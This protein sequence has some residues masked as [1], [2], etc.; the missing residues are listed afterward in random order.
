MSKTQQLPNVLQSKQRLYSQLARRLGDLKQ[1][2][3]KTTDLIEIFQ[4]DLEAM[5]TFT[6]IQA[7]L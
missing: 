6:G 1:Q 7:A 3:M 2:N 4:N 5:K